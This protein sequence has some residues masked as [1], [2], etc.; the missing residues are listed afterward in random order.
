MFPL[1]KFLEKSDYMESKYDVQMLYTDM[2]VD[3]K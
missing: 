3:V 1:N 2:Q